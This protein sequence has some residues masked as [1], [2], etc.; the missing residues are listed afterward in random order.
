M[1]NEISFEEAL[2]KLQSVVKN[3]EGGELNLE[4]ALACFEE[5]VR[6]ARIC[7]ERLGRAEQKVDIL[8]K[9]RENFSENDLP[10]LQQFQ[11]NRG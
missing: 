2:E 3:L 8:M 5:G 4:N 1:N 9:S 11:H 6:L 7:Q 10:E